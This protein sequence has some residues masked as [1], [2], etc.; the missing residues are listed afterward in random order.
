[1]EQSRKNVPCE[2]LANGTT[3]TRAELMRNAHLHR[4]AN[5]NKERGLSGQ[6]AL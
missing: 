2:L 3:M 4:R 5:K 1:M 6:A